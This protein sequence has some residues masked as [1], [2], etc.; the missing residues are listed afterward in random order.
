[1]NKTL[2][3]I[4]REFEVKW[5][6]ELDNFTHKLSG[7]TKIKLSGVFYEELERFVGHLRD[8]AIIQAKK[9]GAREI[10]ICAAIQDSNNRI[11]RGHR[12]HDAIHAMST[13]P[14][15]GKVVKE[16]FMTST[17]RFV[18]RKEAMEIQINAGLQSE[19]ERGI[20]LFSEDL[21]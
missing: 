11:F 15:D 13:R 20:D 2:T 6:E 16:G 7:I 17:N 10:I 9:E 1:M 14:G 12:H 19:S 4:D 3:E 5:N 8:R 18:E 21:Y